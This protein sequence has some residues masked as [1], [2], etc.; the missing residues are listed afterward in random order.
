MTQIVEP[1]YLTKS[2]FCD[3]AYYIFEG[4]RGGFAILAADDRLSPVIGWSREGEFRV[5]NIPANLRAWLDMWS[6]IVDGVRKGRVAPQKG[7]Y[8]EWESMENGRV[9]LYATGKYMETAKW[10]QGSPYNMYCPAVNGSP[11]VTG[12]VA[13]ATAIV[14][15]YHQWP[16]A[17]VG[18][19][20]G[21]TYRDDSGQE[22]AVAGLTLGNVYDWEMMPLTIDDSTPMEEQKQVARLMADVGIMLQ[23]S[24]D[25]GG[26]GAYASD[27]HTGLA[28]HFFYDASAFNYLKSYYSDDQWVDMIIDNL[29]KVGPVVYSGFSEEGGHAFVLDG[30]NAAGQFSINFGWG[31]NYNGY[32]TFPAFDEYT[33]GHQVTLNIKKDEGGAIVEA[34]YIDGNENAPGLTSETTVFKVGEL[35][36][37]DCQYIYNI[38]SRTFNGAV[39]LGIMHRDGSLG[40]I[41]NDEDD[42]VN[43]GPYY[44]VHFYYTECEI[45]EPILIGDRLCMWFRS[46]NTPEWTP[47]LP[48]V[49]DGIP[50]EIPIADAKSLEEVT[51]FRYTSANGELVI[52]TKADAEWSLAD[53]DG[54]QYT[55]GIDFTDGVITIMTKNYPLKSYY[56]TLTKEYDSKTVEFVF[57]SN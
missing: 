30:Y 39:A 13:T 29:E 56:L 10:N 15:R 18:D 33:D 54:V 55:E 36:D 45:T 20:P 27:I 42:D 11:G 31:G 44:G 5:E 26:T 46:E 48:N 14:M 43:I 6:N 16:E 35:F 32:Y 37:V 1:Q 21:Y 12:C 28:E 50:G 24:Y 25:P 52:S 51:S 19:L 40:E 49:E 7:S 41:I 22:Q 8:D 57:G 34:L 38:S 4:D 9:P 3:P 23:S 47:V 17:G 53:A 2:A